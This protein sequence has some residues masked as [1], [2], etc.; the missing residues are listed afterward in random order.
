MEI[1]VKFKIVG[2]FPRN[3]IIQF[4]VLKTHR[5][6]VI[7]DNG[8][9]IVVNVCSPTYY[10]QE[11]YLGFVTEAV[12]ECLF[13]KI[14]FMDVKKHLFETFDGFLERIKIKK[15]SYA[16]SGLEGEATL[17]VGSQNHSEVE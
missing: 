7:L 6:W 1:K 4:F 2:I 13:R 12:K 15:L 16:Y 3:R 17:E 5:V 14:R 8:E 11:Q 9:C 10:K